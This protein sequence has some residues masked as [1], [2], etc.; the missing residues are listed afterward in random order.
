MIIAFSG[1]AGEGK[2]T[3]A[4]FLINQKGFTRVSFA[5]ELKIMCAE[6]FGINIDFFTN[7]ELKDKNFDKPIIL[8]TEHLSNI[9]NHLGKYFKLD[10]NLLDVLVIQHA[11]AEFQ[12]PRE[13]MQYVGTDVCRNSIRST[14]WLDIGRV[15]LEQYGNFVVTDARFENERKLVK[16]LNGHTVRIK[17]EG[18]APIN[19][20]SSDND[21]GRDLDYDYVLYNN[22]SLAD[23]ERKTIQ[24]HSQLQGDLSCQKL[25]EL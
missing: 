1:Y 19:S 17:R 22:S 24:L 10:S 4:E 14:V 2:D 9:I 21:M 18:F 25:S 20:H 12:S 6:S 3:A 13:L 11:G 8:N 15:K 23:L 5:D 7:R 16:G